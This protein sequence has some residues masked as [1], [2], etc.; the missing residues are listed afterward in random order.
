[1]I[2]LYSVITLAVAILLFQSIFSSIV[3]YMNT[4]H[5]PFSFYP[6][7]GLGIAK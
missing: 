7:R 5:T 6:E 3:L 2:V 1:M 4:G